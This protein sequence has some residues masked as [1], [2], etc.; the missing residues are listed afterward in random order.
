MKHIIAPS[1]I[2]LML[3]SFG[4]LGNGQATI[5]GTGSSTNGSGGQVVI[6]SNTSSHPN[7][8]GNGTAG[9]QP[10]QPGAGAANYS[11]IREYNWSQNSTLFIRMYNISIGGKEDLRTNENDRLTLMG[12]GD[13]DAA[14]ISVSDAKRDEAIYTILSS[15]DDL[16]VAIFPLVSESNANTII[17]VINLTHPG[18]VVLPDTDASKPIADYANALG[19]EAILVKDGANLSFAGMNFQVMNPPKGTFN[20]R[21]FTDA[22]NN[23]ISFMLKDR[24]FSMLFCNDIMDGAIANING[25]YTA[26]LKA[27]VLV[28]PNYGAG[29]TGEPFNALASYA[30]PSWGVVEGYK[31]SNIG[32]PDPYAYVSTALNS[33][34]RNVTG[35]WTCKYLLISSYGDKYGANCVLNATAKSTT[36]KGGT[37]TGGTGIPP[38]YTPPV[39]VVPTYP[40]GGAGSIPAGMPTGTGGSTP[41]TGGIGTPGTYPQPG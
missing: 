11:K 10:F 26:A 36:T 21:L 20:D 1:L 29:G 28:T 24:G 19:P 32:I 12:K 13:F 7:I 9:G 34:T 41:P 15:S 6:I 16:E 27:D 39:T 35:L 5:N 31:R 23:A 18:Y 8:S 30:K 38:G 33:Y 4:C 3:V 37:P 2:L 17:Y 40:T 22:N 25:K 14:I